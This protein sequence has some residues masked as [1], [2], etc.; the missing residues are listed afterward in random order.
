MEQIYFDTETYI[1]KTKLNL[2]D[3]KKLIIDSIKKIDSKNKFDSISIPKKDI[4]LN[5][6]CNLGID[7]CKALY[8]S[9]IK[10]PFNT[11]QTE[12]WINIVS[13][14]NPV[15]LNFHNGIFMDKYHS[16]TEINEKNKSFIPTYTYVYYIQMQDIM[17]E[18]DGVLFI[19]GKNKKEYWVRPE[20]DD[21]IIMQADL[22]HAPMPAPNAN[23]DRIVIAGNVGFEFSKKENSLL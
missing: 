23:L 11:I 12:E 2:L 9:T 19:K 4:L 6:I 20:E 8:E 3:S 10:I 1:W 15:Q 18:N 17:N 16:H 21:L 5:K 7:M 13:A 14:K 22:L